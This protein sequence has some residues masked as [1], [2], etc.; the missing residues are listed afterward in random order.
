MAR[1]AAPETIVV[2]FFQESSLDKA[3]AILEVVRDIVKRRWPQV[4]KVRKD[5][6]SSEDGLIPDE[7]RTTSRGLR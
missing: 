7:S 3:Q 4:T 6:M 1:R 2:R 5:R